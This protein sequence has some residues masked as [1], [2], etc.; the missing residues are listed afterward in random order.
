ML[1]LFS[2]KNKFDFEIVLNTNQ[3]SAWE[4]WTSAESLATWWGPEGTD[5][6]HCEVNPVVGGEIFVTMT[7]GSG[8]GKYAGTQWPMQGKF[9][10][11]S[12]KSKFVIEANSWT[13]GKKDESL[14]EHTISVEL[15][16]DGDSTRMRV[17]V[18]I[19]KHGPKAKM[20]AFGMKYGY[21]AQFKK[22][23]ESFD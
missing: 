8:M 9:T 18:N 12:P 5:V 13:E 2:S 14:I 21:K 19:S 3:N 16:P 11:I 17:E 23:S 10:E 15:T 22:L 1:G 4:S 6:T 7:A 20:A